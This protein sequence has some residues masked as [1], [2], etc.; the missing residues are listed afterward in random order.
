MTGDGNAPMP[1]EPAWKAEEERYAY[2]REVLL[3]AYPPPAKLIELGAAPGVQSIAL[4]RCGYHVTAIDLGEAPDTWGDELEG[5]AAHNEKGSMESAFERAG[6]DLILWDLERVPFPL[7]DESFDIIL[8]TEVLEHLRDYP[9]RTL[10]E[11]RRILKPGGIL[12]LTTPNAASLQ[13]RVRLALGHTVHTPLRDWMFGLPHARHAREYTTTELRELTGAA[14]LEVVSVESRHFHIASG[15]QS[16]SAVIA[17]QAIDKLSR[18]RPSL[19][20][21]LAVL[22]RRPPR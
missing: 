21:G 22:A 20:S 19:G 17:K 8:L 18:A 16:R 3:R 5:I 6:V 11:A 10:I 15:R 13:N 9:L 7:A 14:G 1:A 12:L 2:A 4:A